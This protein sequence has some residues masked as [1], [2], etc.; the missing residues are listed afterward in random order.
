MLGKANLEGL[1]TESF[2]FGAKDSI[3]VRAL[4][5]IVE[6]YGIHPS[7]AYTDSPPTETQQLSLD[8]QKSEALLG[9]RAEVSPQE[10]IRW[11]TEE[12]NTH[13]SELF[14]MMIGRMSFLRS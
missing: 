7:V 9:W 5:E 4:L 6:Q 10:A 1:H 14:S 3:S 11:T 12:Y 2:N 8:T 13:S